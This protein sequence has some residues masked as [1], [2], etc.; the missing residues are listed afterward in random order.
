MSIAPDASGNVVDARVLRDNVDA[1]T[2]RNAMDS[3]RRG[4]S[5]P[6]PAAQLL[7]RGRLEFSE[8][9]LFRD[10]GKFQLRT[11]ADAWQQ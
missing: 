11:L 9:W 3:V 4:A 10:D 7:N 8:S 2:V 5:Y 1:Q 6:R